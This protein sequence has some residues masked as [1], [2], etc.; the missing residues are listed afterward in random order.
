VQPRRVFAVRWNSSGALLLLLALLGVEAGAGA[1]SA[2]VVQHIEA[3]A[4]GAFRVASAMDDFLPCVYCH[5]RPATM[6]H[7]FSGESKEQDGLAWVA[8]PKPASAGPLPIATEKQPSPLPLRIVYC[9]W[10]N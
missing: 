3:A 2:E 9:R 4:E 5:A 8:L 10:I 1:P 6:V 7:G